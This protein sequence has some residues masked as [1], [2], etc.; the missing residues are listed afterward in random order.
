MVAKYGSSFV[1]AYLSTMLM[2][3]PSVTRWILKA[4]H[5]HL[6][7]RLVTFMSL[8]TEANRGAASPKTSLP[9]IRPVS[10]NPLYHKRE[11]HVS[12]LQPYRCDIFV[13]NPNNLTTPP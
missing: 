11:R 7:Q 5:W 9:S 2:I 1:T 10:T 8:M 3:L 12:P 13:P 6:V 4:I